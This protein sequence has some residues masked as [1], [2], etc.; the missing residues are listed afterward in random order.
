MPGLSAAAA[1]RTRTEDVG[2]DEKIAGNRNWK[3]TRKFV[4]SEIIVE[5]V[6]DDALH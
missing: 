4:I 1:D 5:I 3:E 6:Q 2:F